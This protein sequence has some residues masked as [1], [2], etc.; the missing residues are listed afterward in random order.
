MAVLAECTKPCFSHRGAHGGSSGCF[1]YNLSTN[2]VPTPLGTLCTCIATSTSKLLLKRLGRQLKHLQL[3][4]R[5]T[6]LI[7]PNT[8]NSI[9]TYNTIC[10]TQADTPACLCPSCILLAG[11]PLSGHAW[12]T[13]TS[14]GSCSSAGFSCPFCWLGP[15]LQVLLLLLLLR[16]RRCVLAGRS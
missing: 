7:W 5:L 6:H 12:D 8:S 14:Q 13:T 1:F 3:Q 11:G 9:S 10:T 16:L 2:S 4:S 15:R